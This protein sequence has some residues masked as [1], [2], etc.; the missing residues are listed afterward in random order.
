MLL[1][2]TSAG[3][4][5]SGELRNLIRAVTLSKV[6]IVKS[7]R[8]LPDVIVIVAD[9]LTIIVAAFVEVALFSAIENAVELVKMGAVV[10]GV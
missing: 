4:S 10:S 5:K 8:S 2:P 1:V 9:S 3:A 7:A 6:T